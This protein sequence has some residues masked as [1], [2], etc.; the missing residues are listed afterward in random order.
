MKKLLSYLTI[1][2]IVLTFVLMPAH[3]EDTMPI[4]EKSFALSNDI[5]YIG[6][7]DSVTLEI[8]DIENVDLI[9]SQ[10]SSADE[11]IA[12]V[13]NEGTITGIAL[14][15]TTI[16]VDIEGVKK[17][18]EV[19][20]VKQIHLYAVGVIDGQIIEE[21][22]YE[23]PAMLAG[24]V[25]FSDEMLEALQ[26]EISDMSKEEI[27]DEYE[28]LGIF[29][30]AQGTIPLK[31][32]TVFEG[33]TTIY[34]LWKEKKNIEITVTPDVKPTQPQKETTP[35]QTTNKPKKQVVNTGDFQSVVMYGGMMSVSIYLYF[36]MKSKKAKI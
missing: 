18:C 29:L 12:T 22:R 35:I 3:A 15:K 31:G 24:Q 4:V 10:W 20:V 33:D 7:D 27:G 28:F 36:V 2:A 6:V 5:V 23:S 1:M 17:S 9:K 13:D 30:D 26:E 11:G 16:T 19:H 21:S 32:N 34:L 14:G 8:L 25:A